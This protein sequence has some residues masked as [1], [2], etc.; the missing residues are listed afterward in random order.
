M[1]LGRMIRSIVET[2]DHGKALTHARGRRDGERKLE[3][4]L[5]AYHESTKSR[6]NCNQ[7]VVNGPSSCSTFAMGL[8]TNCVPAPF[9]PQ[10]TPSSRTP[11]PDCMNT[12][13]PES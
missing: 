8:Y 10:S 7:N 12:S 2:Q 13:E 3:R 11:P 6:R 1:S 5:L 9:P 4:R